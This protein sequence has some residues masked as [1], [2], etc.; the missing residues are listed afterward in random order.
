MQSI[1]FILIF[2][3]LG[4]IGGF[5]LDGLSRHLRMNR[6]ERVANSF[7]QESVQ[8]HKNS[9]YAVILLV[10]LLTFDVRLFGF[11]SLSGFP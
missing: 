11:D 6:H 10:Y 3:I 9:V 4:L 7:W 1:P 8:I 2:G 5:V